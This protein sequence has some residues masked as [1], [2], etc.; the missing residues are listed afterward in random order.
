MTMKH[1]DKKSGAIIRAIKANDPQQIGLSQSA[2]V[3]CMSD[4]LWNRRTVGRV[5]GRMIKR[6]LI[7]RIKNGVFALPKEVE[8]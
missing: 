6:G 2:Q 8:A 1:L 4:N 5:L 7:R 3:L